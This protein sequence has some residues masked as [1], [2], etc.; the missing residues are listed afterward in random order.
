[1]T[2]ALFRQPPQKEIKKHVA[3]VHIGGKLSLLQRKFNNVLLY[4]AYDQ[5]L[6]QE[7]HEIKI[8]DLCELAGFDSNNYAILK[9]TL[10]SLSKTTVTWNL[11]GDD[12]VEEWG[13]STMLSE[14]VIRNGVCRYAYSPSLREKLYKPELYARINLSVMSKFNGSYSF[15]LYENTIRFRGV[16]ST[17]W[18]DVAF[19]R[20][21][22]GIQPG[23]YRQF[24]EFNK[25]VLKPAIREV[26]ETS[27]IL[28]EAQFRRQ[29]R[30]INE[31][32]FHIKDNPQMPIPFPIKEK[33]LQQAREEVMG[34]RAAALYEQL[35][36]F[37][38]TEAQARRVMEDHD[39]ALVA[40]V[41]AV[42]EQEYRAGKVE[43]LPAYTISAIRGDFRRKPAPF[44]RAK[45]EQSA[46]RKQ[47]AER[48]LQEEELQ[49]LE[50]SFE[51][52]RLDAALSALSPSE[53]E[54]LKNAFCQA[55]EEG[56]MPGAA[57]VREQYTKAGFDSMAVKSMFRSYARERLLSKQRDEAAFQA[58]LAARG[59]RPTE[60]TAVA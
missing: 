40:D 33:L 41:L 52:Q 14:A 6:A 10:V 37:G 19:W 1:M 3:A 56:A 30:R 48:Q 34:E 24:K 25:K 51:A 5:L 18:R 44:E 59:K 27:D 35:L 50:A 60:A 15:A 54:T 49:E 36:S 28:L 16:G 42:V 12:D 29:G 8:R 2:T 39:E 55:L 13:V 32:C 43:N 57:L 21:V 9:E 38:L 45:R 4:N 58:F 46:Q 47:A 20:D 26:N 31:I 11:L 53:R 7:K 23:E 17:G 22:L